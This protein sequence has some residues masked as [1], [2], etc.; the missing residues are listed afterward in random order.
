[1]Y[2]FYKKMLL[3]LLLLAGSAQLLAQTVI[4]G[5]IKDGST[6]EALAGVNII[7]K[8]K[9]VGTI[10]DTEGKYTLKVNQAPPFTLTFLKKLM[11]FK[12]SNTGPH[13]SF[14]K[15]IS[16]SFLSSNSTNNL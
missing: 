16:F 6:Q 7:V 5:T 8:G 1:M 9:V 14:F 13:K 11:S 4:S 3:P 15:S 12:G 2:K 10:T